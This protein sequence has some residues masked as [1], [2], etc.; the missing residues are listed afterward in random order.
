MSLSQ[1]LTAEVK[2]H[3][4][5]DS[6]YYHLAKFL[7]AIHRPDAPFHPTFQIRCLPLLVLQFA[8]VLHH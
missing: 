1:A 2:S 4:I 5:I 6:E 8:A 3:Q 7:A